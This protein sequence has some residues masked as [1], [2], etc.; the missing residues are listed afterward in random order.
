MEEVINPITEIATL[1]LQMVRDS[2]ENFP[3]QPISQLNA[4]FQ[5]ITAALESVV[6]VSRSQVMLHP[7]C[8]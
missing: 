5:L 7:V 6:F 3:I 1:A 4:W 8:D 2:L